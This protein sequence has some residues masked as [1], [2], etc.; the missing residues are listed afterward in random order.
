MTATSAIPLFDPD[1]RAGWVVGPKDLLDD[2]KE[3]EQATLLQRKPNRWLS[4][5]FAKPV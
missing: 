1:E 4:V 2:L 5:A 3:V